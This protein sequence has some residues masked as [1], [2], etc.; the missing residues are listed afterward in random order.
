MVRNPNPLRSKLFLLGLVVLVLNDH[1]F[2]LAYPNWFTGKVSD[3]AGLFVLPIFLSAVSEKSIG[4]NYLF[5]ALV[6]IVWKTPLVEPLIIAGKGIGIPLHRTVDYTDL[7]AL[8]ILP[9]SYKYLATIPLSGVI[10]KK[11]A[12]NSF[13]VICFISL[14]STSMAPNFAGEINK[15]YK[16]KASRSNLIKEIK[17]LNCELKTAL[18]D[19]GDSLYVLRNLVVEDDTLIRRATFWIEDKRDH[20]VLTLRDIVTFHSYSTFTAWGARR[21]LRKVAEKHFIE[22]IK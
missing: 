21:R 6:F 19:T 20:S 3:F 5:T 1:Y 12:I 2:K 11:L 8:T 22:E 15:K 9:F 16:I 18:S 14:T 10:K 4:L 13:A 17:E 7:I